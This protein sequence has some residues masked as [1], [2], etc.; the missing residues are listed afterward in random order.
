MNYWNDAV[1][2]VSQGISSITHGGV[3]GISL[4]SFY[5][6][7]HLIREAFVG[8]IVGS[9]PDS[10]EDYIDSRYWVKEVIVHNAAGDGSMEAIT[11]ERLKW[12]ELQDFYGDVIDQQEQGLSPIRRAKWVTASNI[13]EGS[14]N[15]GSFPEDETHT[16]P[17][18]GVTLVHVFGIVSPSRSLYYYF[19]SGGGS[20]DNTAF[21]VVRKTDYD[22]PRYVGVQQVVEDSFGTPS[23]VIA[24][25]AKG[26]PL[27]QDR[28]IK[29]VWSWPG[30]YARHYA[31]YQ[32]N[33]GT[34]TDATPILPVLHIGGKFYVQQ[35]NRYSL[36]PRSVTVRTTDCRQFDA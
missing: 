33:T 31:A 30:T 4:E 32:W 16:L 35:F 17:V 11:R 24:K 6:D 26:T 28:Q 2:Q 15:P 22:H 34:I 19:S 8:I 29:P 27:P 1:T 12:K 36:Q 25:D 7:P 23:F 13:V 18:G 14:I 5:H 10:E 21:A 3:Q 20:G 9:G